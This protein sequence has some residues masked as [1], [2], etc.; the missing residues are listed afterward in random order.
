MARVKGE[1]PNGGVESE[2]FYTDADGTP[3]EKESATACRVVEYGADGEIVATT[4]AGLGE[5]GGR[6][7]AEGATPAPNRSD[8]RT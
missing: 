4:Y 5:G 8:A 7:D 3:A 6:G 1:T 2:I